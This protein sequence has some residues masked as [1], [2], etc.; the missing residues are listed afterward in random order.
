[1]ISEYKDQ[2]F[3]YRAQELFPLH[4]RLRG[5]L[6]QAFSPTWLLV[7]FFIS[8]ATSVHLVMFPPAPAFKGAL[9]LARLSDIPRIGVVAAASFYHS[10]WSVY[11]RLYYESYPLDTL[12]S[13][14]SSFRRA[15]LE[16]DSVV[17]VVEDDLDRSEA[18]RVY[19]ALTATLF[20]HERGPTAG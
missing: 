13:Y 10:S 17:L 6:I 9:R 20:V 12:S 18:A 11:E 5:T 19:D 15:V 16:P 3:G 2:F 4:R 7:L 14:R 8:F 1:M